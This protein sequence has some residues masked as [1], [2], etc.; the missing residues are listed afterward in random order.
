ML[1]KVLA[2]V[3]QTLGTAL[4]ANKIRPALFRLRDIVDGQTKWVSERKHSSP[5][6]LFKELVSDGDHDPGAVTGRVVGSTGAAML[7]PG[8]QLRGVLHDLVVPASVDVDHE[9][10]AAGR[11]LET[12]VVEALGLGQ[13]PAVLVERH[14]VKT[15]SFFVSEIRASFS[16]F[17]SLSFD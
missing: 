10:D 7:H 15:Q 9:A 1:W 6:F 12:G 8:R 16:V 4:N 2:F 5:Q 3:E 13:P 11:P 17:M 14:F